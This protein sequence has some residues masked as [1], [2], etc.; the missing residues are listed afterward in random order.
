MSRIIF[1][2]VLVLLVA[3]VHV[4]DVKA[5]CDK[6]FSDVAADHTACST[7]DKSVGGVK[8]I[9]ATTKA[10]ILKISND[11]R[12]RQQAKN[13]AK[14][15]WD[16]EVAMI[17]QKHAER[18]V[19]GHD[20]N[21]QR[22]I[23]GRF[24]VGQNI[25]IGRSNWELSLRDWYIEVD[26]FV[27]GMGAKDVKEDIGHYTAMVWA[28]T[29]KI[30][31][32]YAKCDY[33]GNDLGYYVCN[34][35]PAG[36]GRN[37]NKPYI[38]G[39]KGS[40]CKTKTSDG[41]CDCGDIECDNGGHLNPENCECQCPNFEWIIKENNCKHDC[42]KAPATPGWFCFSADDCKVYSSMMVECPKMC[43]LCPS[44]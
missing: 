7:I 35:G 19:Y 32:G 21:Y 36:N 11:Y 14:L 39:T 8:G 18:C 13:M 1:N 26:N 30:G 25:A 16:D 33:K 23:P 29:L 43:G 38:S 5:E 22:N 10:Q 2:L 3:S 9:D 41:L 17:A 44:D 20:E 4:S 42:T 34:Y 31:C 27:Y 6:K 40:D 28:T 15:V 12:A 37:I 24:S